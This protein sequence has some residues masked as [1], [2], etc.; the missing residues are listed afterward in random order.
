MSVGAPPPPGS[1][2]TLFYQQQMRPK[3]K[4]AYPD[5]PPQEVVKKMGEMWADLTDE[6]KEEYVE[7]AEQ[8]K[9]QYLEQK[10]KWEDEMKVYVATKA[11]SSD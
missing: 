11:A 9:A 4:A 5:M 1:D 6:D 3:L 2:S 7:E 10:E 8:L